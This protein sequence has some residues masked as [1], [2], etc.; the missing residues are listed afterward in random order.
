[1]TSLA[2]WLQVGAVRGFS[3]VTG[4]WRVAV[5]VTP[6]MP[7]RQRP[8]RFTS[9]RVAPDTGEPC[10]RPGSRLIRCSSTVLVCAQVKTCWSWPPGAVLAATPC[11]SPRPWAPE[12]LPAGTDDKLQK[13][14]EIGADDVLNHYTEDIVARVR[15]LTAGQGVDVIEHVGAA[16]WQRVS[17]A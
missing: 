5:G 14:R 10:Q 4:W 12:S 1:M 3:L 16:V 7:W 11:K 8:G 15:E 6:N 13:A 2:K 17:A 9:R